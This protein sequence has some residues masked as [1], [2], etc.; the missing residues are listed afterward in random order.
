MNVE[1][2]QQLLKPLTDMV[3][4][5]PVDKELE[6]SL[7]KTYPPGSELFESIDKACNEAIA[8]GWMCAQGSEGRRFGRVIEPS[9]ET[10]RLSVDVVDLI[11]IAGPHHRHPL[12]EICMI[13][14]I[15]EGALFDGK[16]RGWCVY[17]PESQHRPTVTNGQALILYL[18]PEGEIDFTR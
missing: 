16:P 8:A 10:G 4:P 7:E 12:G 11:D 13:L 5:M 2:F 15:T 6:K 17:P 18:L 9:D 3:A 1:Q 14:P